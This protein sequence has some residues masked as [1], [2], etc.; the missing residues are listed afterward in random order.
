MLALFA[1]QNGSGFVMRSAAKRRRAAQQGGDCGK[2]EDGK[3]YQE[4]RLRRDAE[5]SLAEDAGQ[6]N[7]QG[8]TE[9]A[10]DKGK[11]QLF[12][13][14]KNSNERRTGAQCFHQADFRA[15]LND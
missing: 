11:Q 12:R 7:S 10:A 14:K 1:P 6:E 2:R 5:D 4:G 15:T 3:K 13:G 8:I 9:T